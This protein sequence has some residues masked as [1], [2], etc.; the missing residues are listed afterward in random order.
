MTCRR[1]TAHFPLRLATIALLAFAAPA[2]AEC[3]APPPAV[4]DLDTTRFYADKEGSV[5]DPALQAQHKAEVA[6]LTDFLHY[7][8][9]SADR[10]LRTASKQKAEDEAQCA[11]SWIAAWAQ[12]GA[13]L[14]KMGGPQ[15]EAER[16]WDLAGTALAYVKVKPFTS[17]EQRAVIQPW[18][19]N[20]ADAARA[21]FDDPGHKRNN[22]WYWL[23]LGLAA[24]SIAA[25]SDRHWQMAMGIL[26]DAARDIQPDGSLPLEM[27]RGARA[28]HYHAF[29]CMALVTLA[30]VSSK[31]GVNGFEINGGAMHRLV[32]LTAQGLAD[33]TV[34]DRLAGTPQER[35]VK[36]FAGWL[37]LYRTH[38]DGPN[39]A[40]LTGHRWLGGDVLLL[41]KA[42][43]TAR[44]LEPQR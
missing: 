26:N 28:L 40:M 23:G 31:G 42:L 4:V 11:L 5:V 36:A 12:S 17:P 39:I 18:L 24:T 27:A 21:Y 41:Q 33:P 1:A 16:K 10:S 6:L 13:L 38:H 15:A 22:H 9:Q 30:E 43:R 35:P 32:A 25:D 44:V 7:V 14:G 8:T 34:F 37:P 19:M 2:L 29:A 20:L 3:A